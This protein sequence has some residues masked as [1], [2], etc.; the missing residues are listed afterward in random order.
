MRTIRRRTF[1]GSVAGAAA[2]VSLAPR[3]L[4]AGGSGAADLVLANANVITM[5]PA[6]PRA[7]AVAIKGGRIVGVGT[8]Q[9]VMLWAG[10][11]TLVRDL[12]GQTR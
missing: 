9:D 11:G 1:L 4:W 10:K 3:L 2:G 6:R 8:N 12:G 5:D 7:Q